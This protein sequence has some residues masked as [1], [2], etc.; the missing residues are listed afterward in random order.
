M[1]DTKFRTNV[2]ETNVA[3][4]NSAQDLVTFGR[5][6]GW[7]FPVLGYAPLPAQHVHVNG[8]LIV[9]AHLDSSPLPARAQ[10]RMDAIFVAGIRPTGWLL[11]HE[12]PK[13]LPANV[14]E[15]EAP[16]PNTILSPKARQ[17]TRSALKAVGTVLG[18]LAVATG[19]VA[20][21]VAAV[22]AFLP[23]ILIA[24]LILIDPILVAVTE[25][26]FWV[27]IDRWDA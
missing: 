10:Q 19:T 5:S 15:V 18:G 1:K 27:E 11:V 8:W 21:A 25:D 9:P 22:V 17:Q 4:G 20:L 23:V 12:A 14:E 7:D 13:L 3:L 6:Q 24:G 2:N 16:T 26:G